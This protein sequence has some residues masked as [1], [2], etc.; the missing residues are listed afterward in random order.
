MVTHPIDTPDLLRSHSTFGGDIVKWATEKL[1]RNIPDIHHLAVQEQQ[2]MLW[3]LAIHI[4][5]KWDCSSIVEI[6]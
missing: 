3:F 6:C 5:Y 4:I 1:Q 2:K